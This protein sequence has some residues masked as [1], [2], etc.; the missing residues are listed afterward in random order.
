VRL[1]PDETS[2]IVG[3]VN[4]GDNVVVVGETK[5]WVKIRPTENCFGWINKKFVEKIEENKRKKT[6]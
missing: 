6:R 5:G 4:G 2:A 1:K 3:R